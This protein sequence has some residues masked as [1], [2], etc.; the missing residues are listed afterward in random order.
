MGED[1]EVDEQMGEESEE[2]VKPRML[3]TPNM[4]TAAEREE[5]EI[6]GHVQYRSW[7]AH[8]VKARGAGQ[9]HPAHEEEQ[10]GEL[11]MICSDYGYMNGEESDLTE[12]TG[13][14]DPENLP[15]LVIRDRRTK[16]ITASYVPEKGQHRFGLKF[17]SNFLK[18]MGHRKVINR[19]D[20]EP[21]LVAL[22]TRAAEDANVE[23]I[24]EESPVGDSKANGIAEA[25]V[26]EVKAQ[27]RAMKSSLEAK[28][29]I[30][31]SSKH[32]VM[33]WMP[34]AAGDL[35][36]RHRVGKD[37]KTAE[38]RRTGRDWKR[39]TMQF[40]ERVHFRPAVTRT[41]VKRKGSL[42]MRM[43]EGRY[44]GHHGRT[45]SILVITEKGVQRATAAR[46]LPEEERWSA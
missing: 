24:P 43:E 21:A 8:C 31:L 6:M 5:H 3:P 42:A 9:K 34:M 41:E 7:C 4:P 35:L 22:K 33:A 46:R 11:P 26:R 2:A 45:G 29:G 20:G 19:S 36:S 38:R 30:E 1:E 32:P 39:P 15:I 40:G 28:L 16:T 37:G 10:E 23:M 14:Q 12:A 27:I 17:F 18:R 44:L 25:A 13:A